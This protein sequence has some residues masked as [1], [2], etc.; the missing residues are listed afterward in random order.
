[1]NNYAIYKAGN[2]AARAA[3]IDALL[4]SGNGEFTFGNPCYCEPPP[5]PPICLK[6]AEVV[7]CAKKKTIGACLRANMFCFGIV[8]PDGSIAAVATN[9]ACGNIVFPAIMFTQPGVY[10]YTIRELNRSGQ[11]RGYGY[12][13]GCDWLMDVIPYP[14]TITVSDDGCGRLKADVTYNNGKPTFV[15]R[16]CPKQRYCC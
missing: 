6:P 16:Y 12:G 11:G 3:P 9:D 15:N 7:L 13:G 5:C 4:T 1:M 14:V 8:N 2:T 10:T